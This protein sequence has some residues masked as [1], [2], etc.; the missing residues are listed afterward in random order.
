VRQQRLLRITRL[1][2]QQKI[3]RLEQCRVAIVGLGAVGGFCLEALARSGVGH[4]TLVDFDIFVPSNLN[5]QI[6]ALESTM[7]KNKAAVAAQR[8]LDIG[9]EIDVRVIEQACSGETVDMIVAGQD[10]VVDAIDSVT[11]KCLLLETCVRRGIPVVSSM[12]AA[13]RK[14]VSRIRTANLMDTHGC[15]LAK[16]VRTRLRRAGVGSGIKVVFSDEQPCNAFESGLDVPEKLEMEKAELENK[17]MESTPGSGARRKVLGSMP[18]V[19]GMF[20]LYLAH[21]ALSELLHT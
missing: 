18:T 1:L 11:A 13:L 14:D 15:P 10:L 9:P 12:G 6:L 20:G 2:G 21:L 16:Q 7:G 17:E 3:D 5:R 8:V 19:T 4:L